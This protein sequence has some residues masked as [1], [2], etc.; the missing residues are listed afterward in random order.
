MQKEPAFVLVYGRSG[1][2]KTTDTGFSFPAGLFLAAP[3]ALKPLPAVC[4]YTPSSVAVSTI[5]EATAAITAAV[6]AG[7]YDSIVVDDFSFLAEQTMVALERK[8]NGFALFG[9]LRDT[10]L[11]FRSAARYAG[12][13]VVVNAWEREPKMRDGMF[14]R[15]GPDLT[16]KLPEQLPAMCDLVLRAD[17]D[18]A[19]QPWPGIYRVN[20]G[21]Q[22]VG[23]D[24]DAGT[25][26]PAPMNLGEILRHN[27][28]TVRR[29]PGLDWQEEVV[30][31]T[32]GQL[33]ADGPKTDHATIEALYG[34]L[35]EQGIHHR[36][37]Y[38]TCR[39]ALDRAMLRRAAAAR[40]STFFGPKKA[41]AGLG[42]APVAAAPGAPAP[43]AP[44]APAAPQK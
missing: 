27:G 23:K 35:I 24:R 39:D 26:D 19:R 44:A 12:L 29:L 6:K 42:P 2:G 18:E 21:N 38:W 16:G 7:G 10:V 5:D 20:G 22:Y 30:E 14:H 32:A 36:H 40:A 13:H 37:A 31:A 8:F 4:G 33:L 15:G 1:I 9:E 25:P 17:R 28:Y 43:G 34:G 11:R 41:L 3:G